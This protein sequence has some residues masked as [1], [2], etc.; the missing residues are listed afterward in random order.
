M[1]CHGIVREYAKRYDRV[2]LFSLPH[3]HTSVAFMYRDLSNLTVISANETKTTELIKNNSSSG[4]LGYDEVKIIGFEYLDRTSNEQLEKQFYKIADVALTKKWDSFF[5]E[6]DFEKELALFERV[7]PK[8]NY[9]FLHEDAPR[10]YRIERQLIDKKYKIFEPAPNFTEN[11][12]DYCTI[13]E[14]ADEIHVI[15]SSFMFL[16]DCLDYTN[17][18]QKLFVHRYAR[19]NESWKLPILK[20]NWV[21]LTLKNKT[22]QNFFSEMLDSCE[23]ILLTHPCSKRLMRKIYR[24]FGLRTRSQKRGASL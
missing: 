15:D 8:N 11:V 1:M 7:A 5:V 19:E 10:N 24:T 12:F 3:N 23:I 22:G 9:V 6:R 13:I 17:P 21:I 20:K 16:I 14:R 4:G 18:K 2:G